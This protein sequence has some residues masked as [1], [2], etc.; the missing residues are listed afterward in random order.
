VPAARRET[1]AEAV[2]RSGNE[3][4]ESGRTAESGQSAIELGDAI[5]DARTG[6]LRRVGGIDVEGPRLDLWRAPIDNEVRGFVTRPEQDWHRAGLHRMH[7][8]TLRV[9]PGADG[10]T[11]RTRVAA[12]AVDFGM[13]AVYRWTLDADDVLWL[14]VEADPYGTWPCPLPRP[15]VGMTIPGEYDHVEW[16][17]LGPG[18]AYRDTA[19]AARVGRY[20]TSVAELQTPYVRPQENGNRRAVRWARLTDAS[21]ATGLSVVGAPHTELTAKPWSTTALDAAEHTNELR[22]DGRIHLNLDHAHQGIGSA[23]AQIRMSA[24]RSAKC[25]SRSARVEGLPGTP[26]RVCHGSGPSCRRYSTP[27]ASSRAR[28][29][30]RRGRNSAKSRSPSVHSASAIAHSRGKA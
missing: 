15:G 21:A 29:S 9:E 18:E 20:L 8:R 17:G 11:V 4:G 6:V 23:A 19:N 13:D 28:C 1:P 14:A 26:G 25:A 7:H 3:L 22:A 27:S 30:S 12:A 5:F 16:F 2:V 24:V 10:L